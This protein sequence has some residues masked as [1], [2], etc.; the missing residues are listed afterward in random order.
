MKTLLIVIWISILASVAYADEPPEDEALQELSALMKMDKL[1]DSMYS[2]IEVMLQNMSTNMGVKPDEQTIFDEYYSK[3][4]LVMKQEMSWEKFEKPL[5]GIYAKHFSAQEIQDMI[6][7]YK[8]Q[9]GKK[10]IEKMPELMQ[11]SMILG[12]KM[13]QAVLPKIDEI[14]KQ[15]SDD[16]EMHRQKE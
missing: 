1:V 15:L 12:Q 8:S 9:T 4:V 13:V 7:F 11:E 5:L 10:S 3:M 6:T 2:Q 14:S 16:L